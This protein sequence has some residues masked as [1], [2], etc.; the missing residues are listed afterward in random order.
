MYNLLC[1]AAAALACFSTANA[2]G[3]GLGAPACRVSHASKV[4]E[5]RDVS[6]AYVGFGEPLSLPTGC[7][8]MAHGIAPPCCRRASAHFRLSEH[9][10]PLV[11]MEERP[12]WPH[13]LLSAD[14]LTQVSRASR[15]SAA[16][17]V[18]SSWSAPGMPRSTPAPRA[19]VSIAVPRCSLRE[20]W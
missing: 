7:T 14:G 13:I 5:S 17:A 19:V 16:G 2:F 12:G 1:V 10:R 3:V 8:R 6:S 15:Y 11:L 9:G 20:R 4:N 18:A